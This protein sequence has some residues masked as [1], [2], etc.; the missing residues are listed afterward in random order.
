MAA[1]AQ[2]GSRCGAAR[3]MLAGNRPVSKTLM[4]AIPLSVIVAFA[5]LLTGCGVDVAGTAAT[6]GAARAREAESLQ[7]APQQVRERVDEAALTARKRLEE[8]EQASNR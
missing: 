3:F 4:A 6:V 7:T 5:A 8:A 1:P 2:A